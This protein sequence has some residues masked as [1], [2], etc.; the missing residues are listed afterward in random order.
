LKGKSV[1]GGLGMMV[2]ERG[3]DDEKKRKE[4]KGKERKEVRR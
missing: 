4:K 3:M 1:R 2:R